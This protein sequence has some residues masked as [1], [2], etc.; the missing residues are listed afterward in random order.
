MQ[1]RHSSSLRSLNCELT[2]KLEGRTEEL[3]QLSVPFRTLQIT[4]IVG[5]ITLLIKFSSRGSVPKFF[6]GMLNVNYFSI[7]DMRSDD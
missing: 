4:N 7:M 5:R 6:I 2:S 3:S 1:R